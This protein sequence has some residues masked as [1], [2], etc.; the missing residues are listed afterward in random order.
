MTQYDA[1]FLED[2]IKE[3]QD[4]FCVACDK[5]FKIYLE[6]QTRSAELR[7]EA[8]GKGAGVLPT[9]YFCPK[10]FYPRF[11]KGNELG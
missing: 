7:D 11:R 2:A 9:N 3:V 5:S 6:R 1:S 8:D 10:C 4:V